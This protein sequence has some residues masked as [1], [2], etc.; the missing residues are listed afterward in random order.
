MKIVS[1]PK[2]SPLEQ[3][4]H[5]FH[6]DFFLQFP[7]VQSGGAAY[8][9]QLDETERRQVFAALELLLAEHPDASDKGLRNAWRRLGAV[10]WPTRGSTRTIF[11]GF[12][13]SM[14]N[15]PFK[16]DARKNARAS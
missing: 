9:K 11:Q 10:A 2:L 6:Q 12:I 4:A 14:P 15:K 13:A 1:T 7:D 5:W 8:L 16:N 3:F